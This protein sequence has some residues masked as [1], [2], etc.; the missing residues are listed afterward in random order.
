MENLAIA[1]TIAISQGRSGLGRVDHDDLVILQQR[2][3]GDKGDFMVGDYSS[4]IGVGSYLDLVDVLSMLH[5][6][7]EAIV[8]DVH[9]V[10]LTV[11][12]SDA[13]GVRGLS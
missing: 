4:G 8:E 9:E 13:E 10:A 5:G 11:L 12:D 6:H 3:I 7:K 1:L 2:D